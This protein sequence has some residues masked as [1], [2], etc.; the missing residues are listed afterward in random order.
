ME[1]PVKSDDGLVKLEGIKMEKI[2]L[3]TRKNGDCRPS[4]RVVSSTSNV[5]FCETCHL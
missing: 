4:P 5:G 1:F 3:K 2:H